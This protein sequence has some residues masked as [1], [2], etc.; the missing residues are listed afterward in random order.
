M[1][2]SDR[3]FLFVDSGRGAAR[4]HVAVLFQKDDSAL[5]E[6]APIRLEGQ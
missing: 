1:R 3:C 6:S 4:R 2:H 5:A